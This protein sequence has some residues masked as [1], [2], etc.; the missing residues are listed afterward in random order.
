MLD[1]TRT[2]NG[3]YGEVHRD[4]K[5]LV[6]ITSAEA[7]VEFDKEEINIAG[8]RWKGHKIT[9]LNGSGSMSGYKITTELIVE[10]AQV[11]EDRGK[12]LVT[13]LILKLDDPE[14]YGAYRVRLKGVTFNGL[15]LL[16]YEVGSIVEEELEF[17][18]TGIEFLDKISA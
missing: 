12:P 8:S 15:P 2:I 18:F 16:S 17:T 3:R 13:E 10:I 4:G 9:G 14:S 5:W 11:C 7:N 1:P 6:N